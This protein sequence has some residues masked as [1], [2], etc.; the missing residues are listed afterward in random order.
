V[1]PRKEDFFETSLVLLSALSDPESLLS[2][3]NETGNFIAA[4][5]Y[6]YS[7][8]S[9]INVPLLEMGN[10]TSYNETV[11]V[12]LKMMKIKVSRKEIMASYVNFS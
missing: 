3:G 4:L 2:P 12:Q 8:S 10:V 6:L 5:S 1:I 7:V 11:L 9:L